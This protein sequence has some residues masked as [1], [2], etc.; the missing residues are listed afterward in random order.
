[1]FDAISTGKCWVRVRRHS[2]EY[3]STLNGEVRR[4]FTGRVTFE[5]RLKGGEGGSHAIT[6]NNGRVHAKTLRLTACCV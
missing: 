1:M 4:G 6:S 2:G 3:R 5:K